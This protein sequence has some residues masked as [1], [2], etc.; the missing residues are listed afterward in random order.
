[1]PP[2]GTARVEDAVILEAAIDGPITLVLE[3]GQD[4]VEDQFTKME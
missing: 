1:M 2:E 4:M 3:S